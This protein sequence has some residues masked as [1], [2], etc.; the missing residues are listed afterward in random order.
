MLRVRLGLRLIGVTARMVS[1]DVNGAWT[2]LGLS[3]RFHLLD[4]LQEMKIGKPTAVQ[5][6]ASRW[7]CGCATKAP[8]TQCHCFVFHSPLARLQSLAVPAIMGGED[9]LMVGQTGICTRM[10]AMCYALRLL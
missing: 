1:T 8:S 7:Q 2:Q 6:C 5:V 10:C 9:V 4:A 3:N